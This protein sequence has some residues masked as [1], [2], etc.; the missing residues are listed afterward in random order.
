LHFYAV[1]LCSKDNVVLKILKFWVLRVP[2]VQIST[3]NEKMKVL[4]NKFQ[5]RIYLMALLVTKLGSRYQKKYSEF[6]NL[7]SEHIGSGAPTSNDFFQTSFKI[8]WIARL[9]FSEKLCKKDKFGEKSI[10]YYHEK[11]DT[12]INRKFRVTTEIG[13]TFFSCYSVAGQLK[14]K[15]WFLSSVWNFQSIE[16]HH[17]QI[18]NSG[19]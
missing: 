14:I 19:T 12:K 3:Q 17:A 11:F 6:W 2:P 16:Y 10:V 4:C 18:W 15:I 1:I 7:T 9:S 8:V 5:R 13:S